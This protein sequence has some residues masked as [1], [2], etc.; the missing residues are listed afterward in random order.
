M[1]DMAYGVK[2][3]WQTLNNVPKSGVFRLSYTCAPEDRKLE[4]RK[5]NLVTF[6]RHTRKFGILPEPGVTEDPEIMWW[7][8]LSGVSDDVFEFLYFCVRMPDFKS[9]SKVFVL[10]DGPGGNGDISFKEFEEGIKKMKCKRFKSKDSNET[11]R[12]RGIF[13]FLD[14]S[15]EGTVSKGEFSILEQIWMEIRLSIENF[16]AFLVRMF[17]DD[18][19]EAW[20]FLIKFGDKTNDSLSM[21]QWVTAVSESGY[22]GPVKPIFG[23]MDKNGNKKVTFEEFE[24]LGN[25]VAL[26]EPAAEEPA[27][28]AKS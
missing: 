1:D 3:G 26:E 17:G 24:A 21:K 15:G 9:F 6:G 19:E 10:I 25:L 13:R 23:Y 28:A 7:A 8:S 12:L 4:T 11:D 18:L 27:P 14:P 5:S 16:V 20:E 22:F 2:Q